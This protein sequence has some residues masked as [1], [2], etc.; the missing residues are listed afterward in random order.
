[1]KISINLGLRKLLIYAA[2]ILEQAV[3]PG[4][5]MACG[6]FF[7]P[8]SRQGWCLNGKDIQHDDSFNYMEKFTTLERAGDKASSFLTGFTFKKLMAPCLCPDC[9]NSFIPVESPICL[10]CGIMFKSREGEDHICGECIRSPKK[11]RRCRAPGVYDKALMAMI[12]S[13]KYKGKIQLARPLGMLLF[14]AFM[15]C[16]D[17][18]SI[19]VIVPVPLHIKR[20][21]KR[22]FN[23][24]FLLIRDWVQ[25]AKSL[26]INFAHIEIDKHLL[27]R[28]RWTQ[29]QTGLDRRQR[30]ANIKNAFSIN[31]SSN[32]SGIIEKRILL[33]DD[34]Y[35]TGATANECAKVLLR[36][37]AESVDVLT[38]A[39]AV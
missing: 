14:S 17:K 19:D 23:Q 1:M 31:E 38:L 7:N 34:V 13:L 24:S 32:I 3:F 12:H 36:G 11:I 26:S 39:R 22:G 8:A 18:E 2:R 33:V 25:L 5:C 21:R 10:S 35:T 6:T 9:S 28:N 30:A 15:S 16:W 4:K 27:L 20:F 29:P 37:G